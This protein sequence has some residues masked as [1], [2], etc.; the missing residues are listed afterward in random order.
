MVAD[1]GCVVLSN[2]E[3]AVAMITAARKPDPRLIR[4]AAQL[5]GA[6]DVSAPRLARLARMERCV[7]VLAYIARCAVK[8]DSVRQEF[9]S[10]LLKHLPESEPLSS[11]LWPHP[12]RF[13]LQAG[14][15]KGGSI[16]TPVWLRPLRKEA[17]A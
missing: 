2:E 3:L 11:E 13:M 6:P 10:E 9:W 8:W 17:A 14:Y 12:S 5:I 1:P 16:P 7:P 15:Q 4:C